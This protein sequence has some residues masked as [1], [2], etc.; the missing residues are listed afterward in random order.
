M[1]YDVTILSRSQPLGRFDPDMIAKVM[2]KMKHDGTR[3]L[4]ERI[5]KKFV[6]LDSGKI[7]ATWE[8]VDTGEETVEEFDTILL[9]TGR[10]PN[11][12][13]I[14][15]EN[16]GIKTV[17]GYIDVDDEN[18]T[19]VDNIYAAGDILLDKPQLTP[20]AIKQGRYLAERLF[21]G[22]TKKVN[23]DHVVTTIFTP[24]EYALVGPTEEEAFKK[25]GRD[26]IDVYL[27]EFNPSEWAFSK[28][29]DHPK[30]TNL[31]FGK[32]LVDKSQNNK[33]IGLHYV[34]TNAGEIMQGYAVAI[35]GGLSKD[36][37]D[38]TIPIHPT[39]AEELVLFSRLKKFD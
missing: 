6:K 3:I 26:N 39:S 4:T 34:G 15:L 8:N 23:Y 11:T 1:G 29:T 13:G 21:N 9:A 35:T 25:Y 24:L 17:N 22:G 18:R 28:F 27:T 14:G 36:V 31:C 5:P 7:E 33:V 16:V 30:P 37:F 19:T 2:I 20:V 32:M 10:N 38:A 12:A